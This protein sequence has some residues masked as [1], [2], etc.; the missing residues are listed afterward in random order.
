MRWTSSVQLFTLKTYPYM[1]TITIN[2]LCIAKSC[3]QIFSPLFSPLNHY[4][5]LKWSEE[6]CIR[7]HN[8]QTCCPPQKSQ[9]YLMTKILCD[10]TQVPGDITSVR[11]LDKVLREE[12]FNESCVMPTNSLFKLIQST[13]TLKLHCKSPVFTCTAYSSFNLPFSQLNLY[14]SGRVRCKG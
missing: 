12:R 5:H 11:W 9:V 2:M 7:Y 4:R 6:L 14:W 3:L 10:M 8:N 13:E 1:R